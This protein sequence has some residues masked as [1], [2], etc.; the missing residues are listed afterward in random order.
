[1]AKPKETTEK[2]FSPDWKSVGIGIVAGMILLALIV[3]AGGRLEKVNLFGA[4]IA[5]PT[6]VSGSPSVPDEK[7]RA[8]ESFPL[9]IFDY[10]GLGD[11]AV[12]Q[13]WA[14]LSIAYSEQKAKYIF[15]YDVPTD[16]AFGYA[17]LDFRFEQTQD[18]TEYKFI[19][20]VME[21]FDDATQCELFI[22]DVSFEGNYVLLGQVA[23]SG[24]S[25]KTSGTE[26]VY[27][28][29]L[30]TFG[31]ADLKAIYE[32]GLSVD[33]DITLGKHTIVVKQISFLR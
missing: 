4:E 10:D 28:I 16:G 29:P 23:L 21:Y 5:F 30:S 3:A 32:I 1:M 31:N 2:S 8:I 27:E 13:G 6:A 24:G 22:K 11:N 18:F 14:K 17:G 26:R 12:K 33:T 20:I 9:K 19:K 15:D 25:L 7:E